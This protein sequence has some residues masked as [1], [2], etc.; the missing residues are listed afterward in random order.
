EVLPRTPHTPEEER[1]EMRTT[2]AEAKIP[3]T[4]RDAD[5]LSEVLP[6]ENLSRRD[7]FDNETIQK[8]RL[9][10]EGGR[11]GERTAADLERE[12]PR[13]SWLWPAIWNADSARSAAAQGVAAALCVALGTLIIGGLSAAGVGPFE[14]LGIDAMTTAVCSAIFF[15]IAW[16]IHSMS[17]AAAVIG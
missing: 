3:S 9:T 15:A 12:Y 10:P 2:N 11:R 1:G 17:R 14:Q 7:L 4:P 6:G 16:G 8:V 5:G 13:S